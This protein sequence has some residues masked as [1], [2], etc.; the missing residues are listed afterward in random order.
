MHKVLVIVVCYNG[1]AYLER[2]LGSAVKA[3][4]DLFV[5]DNASSDGSADWIRENYPDAV[6]IESSE[7]LGFA[8]ANNLGMEYALKHG[9]PYVYLLNQDAWIADDA[10]VKM[11]GVAVRHPGVALFSPMQIKADHSGYDAR[12]EKN[13]IRKVSTS[14]DEVSIVPYVM[15]AHWLIPRRTLETVGGFATIFPLYGEDENYC[16]RARY[17]H[18]NIAIVPSVTA[19]HDRAERQDPLE[20]RIHRDYYMGSLRRLCNPNVHLALVVPYIMLFTFVK[21]VKY[22]SFLPFKAFGKLMKM[23]PEID[24]VRVSSLERY[25]FI[26]H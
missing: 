11:T 24:R 13:V 4:G 6:L 17:K 22:R 12:F 16:D 14:D 23:L 25:A 20:K 19:V 3:G 1:L 5:V 18:M 2:C 7:N 8:K 26:D 15:A 10:L 9:Y 21:A